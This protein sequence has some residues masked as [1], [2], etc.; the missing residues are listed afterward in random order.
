MRSVRLRQ[1]ATVAAP[2][3]RT[4]ARLAAVTMAAPSTRSSA[5]MPRGPVQAPQAQTRPPLAT[6]S[7]RIWPAGGWSANVMSSA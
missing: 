2:A 1:N 4:S 6:K 3:T 7:A 5:V